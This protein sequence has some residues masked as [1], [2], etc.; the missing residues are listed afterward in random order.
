MWDKIIVDRER[1]LTVWAGIL[2]TVYKRNVQIYVYANNHYA[3]YSPATVEMFR[4]LW[5]KRTTR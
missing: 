5:D 3:G 1:D 2:E 4:R